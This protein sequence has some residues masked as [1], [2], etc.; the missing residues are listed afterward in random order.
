MGIIENARTK[1]HT[2]TGNFGGYRKPDVQIV[3]ANIESLGNN[4]DARK[5]LHNRNLSDKTIEHFK[6]GY[7]ASRDAISIPVYK[8]KELINIRYRHLAP[9]KKMRYSQ[10][11]GCETWIYNE[12]GIN[13]AK[14]KGGVLVVEGEFDLMSVWQAG[15][16]NVVSPSSGAQSYGPWIELMDSIPRVW[17]A[18]DNDKPGKK[19]AYD[20]AQRIGID[21][22]FEVTYKGDIKDANDFFA[23]HTYDEFKELIK[24]ARPFYSYIFSGLTDIIADMREN[25]AVKT[26]IKMAPFIEFEEDWLVIMSGDSNTGKT[27]WVLNVASELGDKKIPTL[28]MPF[29]RGIRSVGKRFLQVRHDTKEKDFLLFQDADWDKVIEDASDLPVYFSV[30]KPQD[31]EDVIRRAKRIFNVKFVLIDHL[32]YLVRQVDKKQTEAEAESMMKFK[33]LAQELGIVFIIVHH[34]KKPDTHGKPRKLQKEDLKGS[35]SLYQDPEAVIMLDQIDGSMDVEY[36]V[37]KNKGEQG[38]QTFN[39]TRGTGVMKQSYG[40]TSAQQDYDAA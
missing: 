30:P 18:Y 28:A 24:E 40:V 3:Q 35:S 5:Y 17:I 2:V 9:E 31:V 25:K 20:F 32:N 21:K 14:E 7:D 29:E 36:N 39:F 19:A 15:A 11:K 1:I 13:S 37:V 10:E 22:S 12:D 33:D 23:V 34:I 27:S 26:T 16:K 4:P 38:S 6:L 8:D